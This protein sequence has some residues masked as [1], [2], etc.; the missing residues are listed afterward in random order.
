MEFVPR[1]QLNL[2]R[3]KIYQVPL[4]RQVLIFRE[5]MKGPKHGKLEKKADSRTEVDE[6]LGVGS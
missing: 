4:V 2:S 3:Q 5:I 6:G 1:V